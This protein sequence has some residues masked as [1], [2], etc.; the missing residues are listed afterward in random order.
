MEFRQSNEQ[1]KHA[2]IELLKSSL[3]ETSS[4]KNLHYWIWK[5]EQNPFGKS[6]LL[7]CEGDNRISGVR[8]MMPWIWQLGQKQFKAYRAVD[9]ATHPAD[10][11]KGIFKKLT[12]AMLGELHHNAG[13]FIFNT[14][15][16]QSL[17]GYLKMDWQKWG[18]IP[19]SIVPIFFTSAASAQPQSAT[20]NIDL[21]AS[22][23]SAWNEACVKKGTLF[24]PK[25]PAYLKWRYLENPV[26]SY[27]VYVDE[28]I[29]LA[30]YIKK[31]RF[32]N[33]LR[34]AECITVSQPGLMK[35]RIKGFLSSLLQHNKAAV[36]T[37][38]KDAGKCLSGLCF[39]LPVGPL[40]T[41]R[42]LNTSLQIPNLKNWSPSLGDLELM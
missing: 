12:L 7:I 31:H 39:T 41:T 32:F 19:V 11:G 37:L 18:R 4:P 1:D 16:S 23:C 28:D 15:N 25:S 13:D 42:L 36:I 2:I 14:P 5:H 40:L 30:A 10:Q 17:P 29:F 9:T 20:T 22:L 33:E 6:Q 24:T 27:R 21:T 35:S 34:I 3:G 8:A 26:I 38:S